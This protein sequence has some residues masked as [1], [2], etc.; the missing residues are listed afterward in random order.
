[1]KVILIL[2]SF[3]LGLMMGCGSSPDPKAGRVNSG[4]ELDQLLVLY[5]KNRPKFVIQK[6]KM[7]QAGSCRRATS[8]NRAAQDRVKAAEMRAENSDVLIAVQRE[9]QQAEKECRKK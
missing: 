9:L 6:Q 2:V 5:E 3:G 7:I 1:M 8:L 4:S